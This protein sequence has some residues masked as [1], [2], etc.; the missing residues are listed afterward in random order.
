[1]ERTG[2]GEKGVKVT[3]EKSEE[4]KNAASFS[5]IGFSSF[6]SD[7]ISIERCAVIGLM[8]YIL[9]EFVCTQYDSIAYPIPPKPPNQTCFQKWHF[10]DFSQ[11]IVLRYSHKIY[12]LS[13][14]TCRSVPDIRHVGC[15]TQK[16]SANLPTVSVIVP[17][18]NEPR[19]T[20]LR[21]FHS[22]L[23]R[24]PPSLL[25]EVILVDDASEL[26]KSQCKQRIIPYTYHTL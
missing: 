23:K 24:S 20:L 1:M 19:T 5:G 25:K 26:S 18:L 14:R 11:K 4:D 12:K 17:F 2:P 10:S 21:T 6:V 3:V 9:Y 13:I 7:M 16:Y 15:R 22:V 8:M